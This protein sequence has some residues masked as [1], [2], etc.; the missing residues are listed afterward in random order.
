MS[1]SFTLK[2]RKRSIEKRD[3]LVEVDEEESGF[4]F[5]LDAKEIPMNLNNRFMGISFVSV[6]TA[7]GTGLQKV[8]TGLQKIVELSRRVHQVHEDY[9]SLLPNNWKMP[10]LNRIGGGHFS[11]QKSKNLVKLK[12]SPILR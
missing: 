5:S 3:V 7:V 1:R 2:S 11:Y 9:L 6:G 12:T 4:H 8:G 10:L